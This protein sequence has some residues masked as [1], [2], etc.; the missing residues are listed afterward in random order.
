MAHEQVQKLYDEAFQL[1]QEKNTDRAREL[2]DEALR[3]APDDLSLHALAMHVKKEF[4]TFAHVP[5]AE[6]ILDHDVN[7]RDTLDESQ[8]PFGYADLL[9]TSYSMMGFR[10]KDDDDADTQLVDVAR[11]YCRYAEMILRAGREIDDLPRYVHALYGLERYDE[12][13]D[14][15][16]V[17]I[18][19]KSAA[20]LGLPGLELCDE[21]DQ[22]GDDP[23]ETILNAC[24]ITNRNE[25][26]LEYCRA[27][28]EMEPNQ[29]RWH[30]LLGEE[31]CWLNQPEEAARQWIIAIQKGAHLDYLPE[32]LNTL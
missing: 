11:R 28:R 22:M 27:K 5:H 21:V 19:L 6:F 30:Q 26:A 13:I 17:F 23:T 7:F 32:Q 2:I 3:L 14:I 8:D 12:V 20:E 10:E 29:W 15:G 1:W 25:E 4:N 9:L 31:Y 16:K 18:G 24:H